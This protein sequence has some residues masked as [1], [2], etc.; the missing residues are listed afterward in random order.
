MEKIDN[1]ETRL[2]R[3]IFKELCSYDLNKFNVNGSMQ[4]L[5]SLNY[6]KFV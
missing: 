1:K 2:K 6:F 4:T 3:N 5:C